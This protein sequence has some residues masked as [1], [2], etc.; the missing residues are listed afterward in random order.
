MDKFS[1]NLCASNADSLREAFGKALIPLAQKNKNFVVF[2]AD[3]AEE[4]VPIILEPLS[5]TIFPIWYSRTKYDVSGCWHVYLR[6]YTYCKHFCCI[7]FK[8]L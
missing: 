7:L 2:D 6:R 8:G 5:S 3:V 4:Q 1:P